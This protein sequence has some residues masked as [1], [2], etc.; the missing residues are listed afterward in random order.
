VTLLFHILNFLLFFCSGKAKDFA[1]RMGKTIELYGF[2]ISVK[3]PDVKKFVENFTGEGTIQ[4]MK[5]RHGKGRAPR[6]FAIIQFTTED[7][8]ASMMSRANNVSR[9]L[10]YG[11]AYLKARVMERDIDPKLSVD[12]ASLKGVKLYFGCQISKGGFAVLE[13]MQNVSLSFG[14]GKSKVELKFPHDFVQYK[15]QLS[16]E[17]IWKV[18]LLRPRDKTARYLLLQVVK[19]VFH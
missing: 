17:N 14:S 8:A 10:R 19:F 13:R 2:P 6:A 1:F 11:T 12:V 3:A 15:L 5:V 7:F 4:T 9:A 18:E 16:Y